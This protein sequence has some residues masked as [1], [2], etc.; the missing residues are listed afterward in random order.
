[1]S[2]QTRNSRGRDGQPTRQQPARRGTNC[3]GT[4]RT[5][6]L[7]PYY[8]PDTPVA[9]YHSPAATMSEE[10]SVEAFVS[11]MAGTVSEDDTGGTGTD[12][13]VATST[14]D[15]AI[16]GAA[17]ATDDAAIDGAAT[18]LTGTVSNNDTSSTE[19]DAAVNVATTSTDAAATNDGRRHPPPVV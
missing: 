6:D 8:R 10:D 13:A 18:A 4:T 17:T 3:R 1:M 9:D 19:V 2:R 12:G 5:S 15:A 11:P 7:A 16:D 14:D